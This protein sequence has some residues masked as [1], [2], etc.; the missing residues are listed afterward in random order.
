[1]TQEINA[2]RLGLRV[3][4]NLYVKMV[5]KARHQGKTL[6][7]LCLELFWIYFDEKDSKTTDD[8]LNHTKAPGF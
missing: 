1:M 3:P 7:G 2:K 8:L 5:D 6:N 4:E